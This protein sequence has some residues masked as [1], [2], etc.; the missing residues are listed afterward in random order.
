MQTFIR[1][2]SHFFA[3]LGGLV[4]CG[5]IL[6]VCFSVAGRAIN[7]A[8][9]SDA[10]MGNFPGLAEA[11][12]ATGIGPIVGDNEVLEAGMAFAIFA[13]LPITQ[14]YS[15][16]AS[17]DIL[18][19]HLP[20]RVNNFLV[21]LFELV[22]AAVLILI[23]V[24]LFQGMSSK[25][26]SGQTTFYLQ[27]PIWWAYAASVLAAVAAAFVGSYVALARVTELLT[28]TVILPAEQGAEH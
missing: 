5:I 15:A 2:F 20:R 14:L 10:I 25:M 16:H 19:N 22:I 7:G 28:G 9:H 24:Q 11:L 21:A 27:Y 6:M 18:T 13:F 4:L 26:N 23:A 17:V 3:M 8:L 12:L 1:K